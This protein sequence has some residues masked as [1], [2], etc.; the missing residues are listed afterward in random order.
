MGL[1]LMWDKERDFAWK[2]FLKLATV[3]TVFEVTRN[4]SIISDLREVV[5]E[6]VEMG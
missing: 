1:R 3:S 4:G 6:M 5:V 2:T